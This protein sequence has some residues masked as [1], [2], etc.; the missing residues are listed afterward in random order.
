MTQTPTTKQAL[1]AS[2][3]AAIARLTQARDSVPTLSIQTIYHQADAALWICDAGTQAASICAELKIAL[4]QEAG[5]LASKE[6]TDLDARLL[7]EADVD[8][9]EENLS[10]ARAWAEAIEA[11]VAA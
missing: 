10:D 2:Y 6:F 8:L 1:T 7:R 11:Q 3:D 9:M 4:A 5:F